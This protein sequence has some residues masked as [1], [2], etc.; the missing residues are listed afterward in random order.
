MT[1]TPNTRPSSVPLTVG[2]LKSQASKA[3]VDTERKRQA[4]EPFLMIVDDPNSRRDII[5]P[6][7][8]TS[9]SGERARSLR[10]PR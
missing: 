5:E 7:H 6:G 9:S 1:E 8:D 2:G 4:P 10:E 3:R